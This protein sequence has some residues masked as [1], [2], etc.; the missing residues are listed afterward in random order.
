MRVRVLYPRRI[1]LALEMTMTLQGFNEC[2]QASLEL[3][4]I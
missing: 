1:G 2:S 3:C 4:R